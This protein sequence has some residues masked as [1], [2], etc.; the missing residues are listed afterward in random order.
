M[1]IELFSVPGCS[2]CVTVMRSLRAI[3]KDVS[4]IELEEVDLSLDPARGVQYGILGCPALVIDAKL[5]V[6]GAISEKRLRRLL[7]AIQTRVPTVRS[8]VQDTGPGSLDPCCSAEAR[9]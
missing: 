6:V 5:E 8:E 4:A 2:A 9:G 3:Q 7:H 1:K